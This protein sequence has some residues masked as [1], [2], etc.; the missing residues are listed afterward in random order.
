M[1][2]RK[3]RRKPGKACP[4]GLIKSGERK[5]RKIGWNHLRPQGS[6]KEKSTGL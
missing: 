4:P 6:S 1:P 5:R 2:L 3:L